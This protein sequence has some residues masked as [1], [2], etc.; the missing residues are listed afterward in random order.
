MHPEYADLQGV[1]GASSNPERQAVDETYLTASLK[2]DLRV[3]AWE[4]V[5]S[6]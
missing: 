1:Q 5:D 2:G 6:A 3:W 4:A